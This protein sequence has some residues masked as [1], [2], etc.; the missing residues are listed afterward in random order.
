MNIRHDSPEMEKVAKA[1]H[2]LGAV[3]NFA[4]VV[5][6]VVGVAWHLWA[7]KQHDVGED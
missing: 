4:S 3:L 5:V 1:W 2:N 6:S 7:A